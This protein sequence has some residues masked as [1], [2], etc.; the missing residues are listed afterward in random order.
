M[1]MLIF[2]TPWPTV[3]NKVRRTPVCCKIYKQRVW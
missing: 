3:Y 2:D 1:E